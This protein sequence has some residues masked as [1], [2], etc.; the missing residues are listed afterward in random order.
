MHKI[1]KNT[2]ASD[3]FILDTGI[4]LKASSSYEITQSEFLLWVASLDIISYINSGSVVVN[5]GSI[6]LSASEGIR[7][8]QYPDRITVKSN[9]TDVTRVATDIN[10]TGSA[11][12]TDDGN[13]Q[14]TVDIGTTGSTAIPEYGVD[15]VSPSTNDAWVLRESGPLNGSPIG[16]LLAL[17]RTDV[18]YKFSYKTIS[19][20]IVRAPLV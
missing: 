3:I 7:A 5:N 16:L 15:P 6:D 17:T 18:T 10:F 20:A 13:G 12:V 14:V 19:G 1:L 11:T 4:N 2:T 8:L 9:S